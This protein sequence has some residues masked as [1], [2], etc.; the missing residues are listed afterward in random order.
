MQNPKICLFL[1]SNVQHS[2]KTYHAHQETR[3]R[4]KQATETDPQESQILEL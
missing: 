2:L 3:P 1:I 4:E